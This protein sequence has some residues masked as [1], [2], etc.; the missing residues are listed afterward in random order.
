M[1]DTEPMDEWDDE[2]VE[3]GADDVGEEADIVDDDED[4]EEVSED[5]DD[6]DISDDEDDPVRIEA[7]H[8]P[9]DA[10]KI[11]VLTGDDRQTDDRLDEN[12]LTRIIGLRVRMLQEVP[13]VVFVDIKPGMT[14]RQIAELELVN[15]K[16]PFI[17]RRF[18]RMDTNGVAICEDWR[19]SELGLPA[20]T[21]L[22]IA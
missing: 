15:K 13:S 1:S 21:T 3:G 4:E 5:S 12:E 19:V 7:T 8:I 22:E 18:I 14:D 17:V 11:R 2:P 10:K 20:F 16:L 6:E 9:D